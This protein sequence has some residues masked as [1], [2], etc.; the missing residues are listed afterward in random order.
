MST[1]KG[2]LEFIVGLNQLLFS[3]RKSFEMNGER[4]ECFLQFMSASLSA[5]SIRTPFVGEGPCPPV[6][7]PRRQWCPR[8]P[9]LRSDTAHLLTGSLYFCNHKLE[10]VKLFHG[11]TDLKGEAEVQNASKTF[12]TESVAIKP[13]SLVF[14]IALGTA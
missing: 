8:V 13:R 4:F 2:L 11:L 6:V 14:H 7:K 9:E 10:L 12:N 5:T 1:L 3:F